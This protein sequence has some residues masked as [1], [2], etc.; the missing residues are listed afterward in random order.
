MYARGKTLFFFFL[1]LFGKSCQVGCKVLII[2]SL[3]K[4]SYQLHFVLYIK[5]DR[6]FKSECVFHVIHQLALP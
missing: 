2:N 1:L 4:F 6:L 3:V 5:I